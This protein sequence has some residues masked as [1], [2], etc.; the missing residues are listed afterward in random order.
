M[1]EQ[2][3]EQIITLSVLIITILCL[4][5]LTEKW[6]NPC[7]RYA[8]W[9]LVV[10]KLLI[11]IP[12]FESTVS[13]MN[14]AYEIE[15]RSVQY[16]FE[17]QEKERESISVEKA[18]PGK[19]EVSGTGEIDRHSLQK[20]SIADLCV[21]IWVAGALSLAAVFLWSNLHFTRFLRRNRIRIGRMKGKINI[22]EVA[23]IQS[24]C[25][26]GFFLPSVYLPEGRKLSREQREFIL[27]HEYTHY[28]HGDHVWALVRCLCVILYWYH[29]LV[30]LAAYR[31]GRDG[32]LACDAATIKAI[33][34]ENRVEYG[35]ILIEIARGARKAP[36]AFR[37]FECFAGAAGGKREMKKRMQLIVN[38]PQTKFRA[39]LA[40]VLVCVW[41]TGCTFGSAVS[42]KSSPIQ[43]KEEKGAEEYVEREENVIESDTQNDTENE[44]RVEAGQVM[45]KSFPEEDKVCIRVQPSVLREDISS[46]YIPEDADQEWLQRFIK[47]MPAEGKPYQKRWEG[48][49]ETG[50]QIYYQDRQFVVFEGG[51]VYYHYV[52]EAN[53][54]M[55]YFEEVPKLCDYI[56]ILLL[57]K[58]GYDKFDPADIKGILSAKLDV[59]CV[60]TDNELY[61]QTITDR[62]TLKLFEDWFRNARY[63]YGGMECG[64]QCSCL[65][66]TLEDGRTVR[67]SMAADNCPNFAINGV[68]YDYRPSPDWNQEEFYAC[69]DE[70]PWNS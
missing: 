26:F 48:M 17:G 31:S 15:E 42:E 52:N 62:K 22:Y 34:E 56:Q 1:I 4:T 12:E 43:I 14:A 18:E 21:M 13:V 61:S 36:S 33:G 3:A 27:A 47:G 2:V 28:K 55:E 32:E 66:L 20:I 63:I 53:E 46:F 40:L 41:I 70:I 16:L 35:K 58:L 30:W 54:E 19:R 10:I 7:I 68:Y 57:E 11:P 60:F 8:L 64:N 49:K 24:P 9:L 37:I 51:Y 50:W 5:F 45:L 6:I 25:L 23:G 38:R 44:N 39:L 59:R 69:F 29:P 67:L 65:E